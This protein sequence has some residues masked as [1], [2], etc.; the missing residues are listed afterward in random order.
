MSRSIHIQEQ[1]CRFCSPLDRSPTN[2]LA[3]T[4]E[5][6]AHL[7]GVRRESV[8]GAARKLR[9]PTRS[10]ATGGGSRSSIATG[11]KSARARLSSDRSGGGVGGL[12]AAENPRVARRFRTP[13]SANVPKVRDNERRWVGRIAHASD[14]WRSGR[15]TGAEN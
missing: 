7:L 5:L 14:S 13:P 3:L 1:V 6:V 2:E 9:P 11:S 10:C 4:H 12:D 15:R 8:T